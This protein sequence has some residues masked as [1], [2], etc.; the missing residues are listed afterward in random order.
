MIIAGMM[1]RFTFENRGEIPALWSVFGPRIGTIPALVEQ[2]A[3]GVIRGIPGGSGFDYLAG[4]EVSE[5]GALP[6]DVTTALIPAQQYAVF[7]HPGSVST[8]CETIDYAFHRWLPD[9][10]RAVTADPD[11][12]EYYGKEFRPETGTGDIEIWLP[13][14]D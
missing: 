9:F 2:V 1:R 14:K 8:L 3:Y 13:I 7:A 11:F 5:V 12:I 4:V 6:A 10:G